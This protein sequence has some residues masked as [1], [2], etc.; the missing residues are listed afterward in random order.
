MSEKDTKRGVAL[1]ALFGIVA[2]FVT[3]ILTAP[4]SGKETRKDIKETAHKVGGE[5]E[6]KLKALYQELN[7]VGA[8]VKKKAEGAVGKAGKE[9]TE[10]LDQA[11]SVKQKIK[12]LLS[13]IRD[14]EAG[15]KAVD[16]VLAEAEKLIAEAR[17][18]TK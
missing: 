7:D 1:G 4:K 9:L 8:Q 18:K 16:T 10:L 14:G 6:K 5:A 2:G 11:D 3:G 17:K 12:E 13:T 15:D